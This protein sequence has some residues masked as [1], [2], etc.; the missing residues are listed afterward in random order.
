MQAHLETLRRQIAECEM[1]R[2]LATDRQKQELFKKL[3]EHYKVLAAQIEMAM[4]ERTP[5][6]FLGRKTQEPFPMREE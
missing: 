3:A 4:S 6:T 2:D 5:I 1:I